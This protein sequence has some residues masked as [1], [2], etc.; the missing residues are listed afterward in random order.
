MDS[1]SYLYYVC[2]SCHILSVLPTPKTSLKQI[3]DGI[4]GVAASKPQTIYWVPVHAIQSSNDTTLSGP[5]PNL[6]FAHH[7]LRYRSRHY[8][9]QW[10][11]SSTDLT[12]C[13]ESHCWE[14]LVTSHLLLQPHGTSN[15]PSFTQRGDSA[16]GAWHQRVL[17][18]FEVHQCPKN[19]H[20][21]ARNHDL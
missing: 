9:N 7:L 20:I 18:D 17:D 2:S 14:P 1:A 12:L 10:P 3:V 19:H 21:G 5:S 13:W 8:P 6:P 15:F 16:S 4:L 11:S